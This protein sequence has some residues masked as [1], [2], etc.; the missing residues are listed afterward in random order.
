MRPKFLVGLA[1]ALALLGV[2]GGYI[3]ITQSRRDIM[4]LLQTEAET[5]TD[6][7]A[8]S[9]E[10]AVQAY[11]EVESLLETHLLNTANM[12]LH[13][14]A[15][16]LAATWNQA[17]PGL[18]EKTRLLCP[19]TAGANGNPNAPCQAGARVARARVVRRAGVCG[20]APPE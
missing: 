18:S 20:L 1:A 6:A 4:D 14:S 9:A 7:L 11:A 8:I 17:K 13:R 12:L 3:E 19:K 10:N 2:A 5:V 16:D 15:E